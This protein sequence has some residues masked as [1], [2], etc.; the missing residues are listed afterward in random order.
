MF[1]QSLLTKGNNFIRCVCSMRV[2]EIT[3]C[4]CSKGSNYTLSVWLNVFKEILS[5]THSIIKAR[6]CLTIYNSRFN[7]ISPVY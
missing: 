3:Q 1:D 5:I 4:V 7:T 6:Q 2:G